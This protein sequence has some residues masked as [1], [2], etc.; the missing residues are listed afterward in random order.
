MTDDQSFFLRPT[1]VVGLGGT[2]YKIAVRLKA[3]LR[4]QFN[5]TDDYRRAVRFLVLDTAY[6]NF[7]A[8]QPNHPDREA[9]GLAVGNEFVRISDVP[10]QDLMTMRHEKAGIH[11]IL[12][13]VLRASHIDQGAQQVRRFGRI[14]LFHCY[15]DIEKRVS[16]I[17]RDLLRIGRDNDAAD[18]TRIDE[19]QRLRIY[20]VCSICGG[21]GSGTFIDIAYILRHLAQKAGN[22]PARD[23]EIIGMFLLPEAFPNILSTGASNLRA[24]AFAALLDLEYFNQDTLD[25]EVLYDEV[26]KGQSIRIAGK[27]YNLSY[28]V[29]GGN[30]EGGT[31]DGVEQIAPILA[32]SIMAITFTRVGKQLDATLDNIRVILDNYDTSGYRRSYSALGLSKISHPTA[33]VQQR[34]LDTLRHR[35]IQTY[36]LGDLPDV[37][38]MEDA[39]EWFN[40]SR[41]N[42]IYD[43]IGS[44]SRLAISQPLDELSLIIEGVNKPLNR[45]RTAFW[46]THQNLLVAIETEFNTQIPNVLEKLQENLLKDLEDR[47]E[48]DGLRLSNQWLYQREEELYTWLI[49]Q[50]TRVSTPN[51]DSRINRSIQNISNVSGVLFNQMGALRKRTSEEATQL[52]RFF[53]DQARIIVVEEIIPTIVQQLLP[54][55]QQLRMQLVESISYWEDCLRQ[56]DRSFRDNKKPISTETTITLKPIEVIDQNIRTFVQNI[57]ETR[58]PLELLWNQMRGLGDNS[59]RTVSK[60]LH[61]EH[62][63]AL[64]SIITSYTQIQYDIYNTQSGNIFQDLLVESSSVAERLNELTDKGS[65]LLLVNNATFSS[66]IPPVIRVVGIYNDEENVNSSVIKDAVS[67]SDL[68]IVTT[69]DESQIIYVHTVHG[70]SLQSLESFEDYKSQYEF[71]TQQTDRLL[72]LNP[73][74]EE[75]PYNPGSSHFINPT[76]L[77]TFFAR[78]LAYGW[79]QFDTSMGQRFTYFETKFA[80]LL[81]VYLARQITNIKREMS[82]LQSNQQAIDSEAAFRSKKSDLEYLEALHSALSEAFDTQYYHMIPVIYYEDGDLVVRPATTLQDIWD[83]LIGGSLRSFAKIFKETFQSYFSECY[84]DDHFAQL[85]PLKQFISNYGTELLN[86]DSMQDDVLL[87][88]EPNDR[89]FQE[90]LVLILAGYFTRESRIKVMRGVPY[91]WGVT[92]D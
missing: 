19:R 22:M 29:G 23:V 9:V 38:G 39:S 49:Q 92:N 81:L 66:E 76:D 67:T 20:V 42:S 53:D 6:E 62:L 11:S 88:Q 55:I 58:T 59:I 8:R 27:P 82:T 74:L 90:R 41:I 77:R 13:H 84:G 34:F 70:I 85:T 72:H 31:L 47:I 71:V 17:I 78:T 54:Y 25:D 57:V 91:Y 32:D 87:S 43:A 2:G 45:L 40:T 28:L 1:L 56:I 15:N 50:Q 33:W 24:N 48:S 26:I 61:P 5:D 35:I 60:S 68:S 63:S 80:D 46:E 51:Y 18:N 89:E 21:T 36:L 14:A 65:P 12:P 79:I 86:R 3:R 64:D 44:G 16:P 83:C 30:R 7:T 75:A 73:M 4:E 10:L 52:I 69:H 37:S